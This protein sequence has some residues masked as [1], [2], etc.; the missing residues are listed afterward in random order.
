MS[1]CLT[2][3]KYAFF[4]LHLKIV[5]SSGQ[6][7]SSK[8]FKIHVNLFLQYKYHEGAVD[9]CELLYIR[10]DHVLN[11]TSRERMGYDLRYLALFHHFFFFQFSLPKY[12][13]FNSQG[14]QPTGRSMFPMTSLVTQSFENSLKTSMAD[15]PHR[16]QLPTS[17]RYH[18]AL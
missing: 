17:T 11:S 4:T 15:L 9:V 14:L 16:L 6:H 13:M 10:K 8:L 18:L 5:R 7:A 1:E 3:K 2:P 12:V